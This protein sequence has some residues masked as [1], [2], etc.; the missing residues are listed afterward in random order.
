MR[1]ILLA[2][3]VMGAFAATAVEESY[4]YWMIDTTDGTAAQFTYD[5]VQVRAFETA[6]GI[7]SEGTALTLYYGNG[8]V[9]AG[10]PSYVSDVAATSG[11][12][13]YAGL[14]S[15]SGSSFSYVVELFNDGAKVGRSGP[16]AFSDAM[17]K[18]YISTVS[19][20]GGGVPAMGTWSA[21]GFTAVPEPNSALLLILGCAALGL[22]RRKARELK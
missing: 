8:N 19:S 7:D 1:S 10:E 18:S 15:T 6:A 4:L 11:L 17:A 9:A 21:G 16:L 13:L 20:Y 22:R 5:S 14:A 3:A 2:M 12:S